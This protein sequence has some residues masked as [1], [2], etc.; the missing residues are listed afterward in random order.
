MH[1]AGEK[2]SAIQVLH[3]LYGERLKQQIMVRL[4]R[5]LAGRVDPDDVLQEAFVDI[6]AR[7]GNFQPERNVP[8]FQWLRMIVQERIIA[9][10]RRHLLTGKRDARREQ[11]W[12]GD[13]ASDESAHSLADLILVDDTSPSGRV[14]REERLSRLAAALE[15]ITLTDREIILMRVYENLSNDDTAEALGIEPEAAKKRLTRA[16][17][18]LGELLRAAPEFA[19]ESGRFP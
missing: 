10:H 5:R 3:S 4:D 9:T 18:R 8:L 6:M 13:G 19:S 1:S 7:L 15:E 17:R 2:S 14:L 12:R 16:I 11:G